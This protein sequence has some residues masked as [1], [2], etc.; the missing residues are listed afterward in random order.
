LDQGIIQAKPKVGKPASKELVAVTYDN[1]IFRGWKVEAKDAKLIGIEEELKSRME[2]PIAIMFDDGNHIFADERGGGWIR[3]EQGDAHRIKLLGFEKVLEEKF[4]SKLICPNC[5]TTFDSERGF[6]THRGQNKCRSSELMEIEELSKLRRSRQVSSTR[7]GKTVR[8]IET[9]SVRTCENEEIVSCGD[10]IYLG[11]KIDGSASATPG[12]RR[13]IGMANTTFG[14]LNN[15]WKSNSLPRK[16][17]AALYRAIILSI[18]LYNA[19][20]WP[21]KIQDIKALEGAH[22]TMLRRMMAN[23]NKDE[24]FHNEDLFKIFG[25]PKI[26]EIITHKRLSWISHA[27]RRSPTDRSHKAV[28]AA[29]S[30][31]N[32]IWTKW[33]MRDC[34][35]RTSILTSWPW[36]ARRGATFGGETN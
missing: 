17:K 9:V 2:K 5:H 4:Q 31:H 20:V 28:I 21:I 6:K 11:S 19:E 1:G 36:R 8:E 26:S 10:F 30:N 23:E 33:I 22:I 13:R 15:I 12:I 34:E 14:S 27:L 29:L 24:H 18:M 3:D 7:R 16:T 25:M 35:R 32:S